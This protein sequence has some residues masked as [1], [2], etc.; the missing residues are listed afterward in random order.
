MNGLLF[1][2]SLCDSRAFFLII[3]P[4]LLALIM[5]IMEAWERF[6]DYL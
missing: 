1:I 2:Q 3:Y 6:A 5:A 4:F